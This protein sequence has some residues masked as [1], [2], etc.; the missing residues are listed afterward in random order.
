MDRLLKRGDIFKVREGMKVCA[1]IPEKFDFYGNYLLSLSEKMRQTTIEI[2]RKYVISEDDK[3]RYMVELEK[4]MYKFLSKHK[5]EMDNENIKLFM[6]K[7]KLNMEAEEFDTSIFVGEYVVVNIDC[8][9]NKVTAK[10][11]NNGTFDSESLEVEFFQKHGSSPFIDFDDIY[12]EGEV[13]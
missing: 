6:S 12:L 10:K 11:L 13:V 1:S 4:E 8:Y 2:G 5:I 7:V 3:K 9:E